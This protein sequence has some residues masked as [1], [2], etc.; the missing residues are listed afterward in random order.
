MILYVWS[1]NDAAPFMNIKRHGTIQQW[2]RQGCFIASLEYSASSPDS[3]Q[4]K[5]ILR[6]RDC[7]GVRAD[8]QASSLLSWLRFVGFLREWSLPW[9][10]GSPGIFFNKRHQKHLCRR[11]SR[12]SAKQQRSELCDTLCSN[13]DVFR[14]KKIGHWRMMFLCEPQR[15]HSQVVSL[16]LALQELIKI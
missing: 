8:S 10:D 15:H 4:L 3:L 2:R 6:G 9:G 14:W 11:V 5:F 7:Y 1:S 13:L 12:C 16:T